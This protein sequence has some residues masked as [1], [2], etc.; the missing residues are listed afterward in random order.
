LLTVIGMLLA[1]VFPVASR[2]EAMSVWLPLATVVVSQAIE[3]GP[4]LDV[5]LDATVRPATVTVYVLDVPLAPSSHSV[6]QDVPLTV[7]PLVGWVI[8][9]RSVPLPPFVTVTVA[10]AVAVA[11][12]ASRTVAVS[13]WAPFVAVVVFQA[14]VFEVAS[15]ISA[16]PSTARV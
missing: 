10:V 8:E 4:R 16:V 11:L 3:T 12:V 13:V 15:V 5:V 1:P 14:T 6:I 9:T 7:A 2:A